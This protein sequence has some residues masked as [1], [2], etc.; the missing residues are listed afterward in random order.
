MTDR[1]ASWDT[2]R[3]LLMLLGIPFHATL[4]YSYLAN[5][6]VVSDD[7]SMVAETIGNLLHAFRMAVFFVVA[8]FFAAHAITRKGSSAWLTARWRNLGLPLLAGAIC[9]LP[10]LLLLRAM[11]MSD[12]GPD[13]GDWVRLLVQSPGPHWTGHLWFLIVLLEMSLATA[14]LWSKGRQHVERLGRWMA[15]QPVLLLAIMVIPCV[16]LPRLIMAITGLEDTSPAVLLDL[17]R[18]AEYAPYFLLGLM[19]F[20]VPD[21]ME[22]F[23]RLRLSSA[24]TAIAACIL[25]AV[26]DSAGLHAFAIAEKAAAGMLMAALLI[27]LARRYF[28]TPREAIRWLVGAAFTI[29]LFHYPIVCLTAYVLEY[30]NWS[31]E[32][33]FAIVTA[34]ALLVSCAIHI[35]IARNGVLLLLFNGRSRPPKPIDISA[36]ASAA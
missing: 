10:L 2:L 25:Y 26:C 11:D 3:A 6:V 1:D 24:I 27:G 12:A 13:T 19:L 15:D 18:F 34:T 33:R 36:A 17:R 20:V 29:Y 5:S 14:L 31:V 30:V 28:S 32:L 7:P 21:F 9:F 16:L 23:T 35:L 22:S 4:P 8:G